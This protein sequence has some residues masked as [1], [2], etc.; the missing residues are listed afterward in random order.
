MRTV[1][2]LFRF[3]AIFLPAA[4]TVKNLL[5]VLVAGESM[6]EYLPL[7]LCGLAMFFLLWEAFFPS[8]FLEN[9]IYSTT[10]PGAVS[11]LLFANWTHYPR[12][13]FMGLFSFVYHAI[14]IFAALMLL[15]CGRCRP[16]ARYLPGCFGL[17]VVL[18]VPI[19]F[20]NKAFDTNYLFINIPSPGSPLV[21][22]ERLLGNPG[23]ILGLAAVVWLVWLVLYLPWMLRERRYRKMLRRAPVNRTRFDI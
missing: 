1:D 10:L 6:R 21:P 20:F 23:Y 2:R 15:A 4:E 11:A 18:A 13:H 17:L 5:L 7:H 14:L 22:L 19:F 12:L 8:R 9:L 16:Q 3:T